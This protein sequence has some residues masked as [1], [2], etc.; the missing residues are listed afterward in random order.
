MISVLY[1]DDEESLLD[2]TKIFLEKTGLFQIET[3]ISPLDALKRLEEKSFDALISDYEMPVMNGLELLKRVRSGGKNIPFIIF[4]GRGREE[5]VIK[6]FD[7]GADSYMQKGGAT[8]AQFTELAHK[9]KQAVQSRQADLAMRSSEEK[10]S[11]VFALSPIPMA[12][13]EYASHR[14]VDVNEEFLECSGFRR[15]EVIGRTALDL[16]LFGDPSI[17]DRLNAAIEGGEKIRN[18][19]IEI[20]E[21]NGVRG[22][23]LFSAGVFRMGDEAFLLTF[24]IDI[25]D[26]KQS[27][28]E[29]RTRDAILQAI[30]VSAG[31]L[32]GARDIDR[33]ISE[34][35]ES[36]GSAVG[37]DR[38]YIYTRSGTP[39]RPLAKI[40]YEWVKEGVE[41]WIDNPRCNLIPYREMGFGENARLLR[42]GE[43]VIY[44]EGISLTGTSGETPAKE[45]CNA[46][47]VPI[48][49]RNEIWGIIGFETPVRREWLPGVLDAL[50]TSGVLI[51]SA[52]E[53]SMR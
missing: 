16:G 5:V 26:R 24:T 28:L 30:A 45:R 7:L 11:K 2:L 53:R 39:D 13:S 19:E 15:E 51:S 4:T 43:I 10:F 1:V 21:K 8:I 49:V 9:I 37:V 46:A 33:A 41:P 14:F 48:L 17:Y 18:V 20:V 25:T 29:I 52:I 6:A 22:N 32:L 31:S 47:I 36:L 23:K 12:I 38:V 27:E 44:S 42:N 40:A 35:L 50:K 3:A 34:T